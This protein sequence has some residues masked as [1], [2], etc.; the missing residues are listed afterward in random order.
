M[1]EGYATLGN[2]YLL[3]SAYA[4]DVKMSVE[5]III[6]NGRVGYKLSQQRNMVKALRDKTIIKFI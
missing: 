4:Y 5:I 2:L 1:K 3:I 6:F